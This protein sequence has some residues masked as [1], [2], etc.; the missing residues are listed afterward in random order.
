MQARDWLSRRDY[1]DLDA[2]A[3]RA[4]RAAGASFQDDAVAERWLNEAAAIAAEHPAVLLAQYRYHLYKHRYE[5]AEQFARRCLEQVSKELE[6]PSALLDTS[7]SDADFTSMDP[8]IRFWLFGM[9]ALGYVVLRSGR[10]SE[11]KALLNKVIEL[12]PSDQTK[13]RVLLGVIEEAPQDETE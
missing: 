1:L 12:D 4:L 10:L 11:A 13:T 6:L 8:R 7:P 5:D 3:E 9:Q 2:R